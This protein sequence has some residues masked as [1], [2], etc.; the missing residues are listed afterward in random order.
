MTLII[1]TNSFPFG[2]GEE[3]FIEELNFLAKHYD[4]IILI[5]ENSNGKKR[6]IKQQNIKIISLTEDSKWSKLSLILSYTFWLLYIKVLKKSKNLNNDISIKSF[7]KFWNKIYIAKKIKQTLEKNKIN[8]NDTIF[9]SYWFNLVGSA[10]IY[11]K[12]KTKNIKLVVKIHGYDFNQ[13]RY[14][15]FNF[16]HRDFELTQ[17]EHLISISKFG[18]NY[19]AKN[20]ESNINTTVIR[21]GTK[22][23]GLQ[24]KKDKTNTLKIVSC[25]S[26]IPIKR[27]H[28]I[29]EILGKIKDIPIEWTHLGGGILLDEL[30]SRSKMLSK[31][32]KTTFTGHLNQKELIEHYKNNYFD[33]FIHLSETEG[34]PVSMMEAISFGIPI[35]SYNTG[36]VSEIV[37]KK[38]GFLINSVNDAEKHIIEIANKNSVETEKIRN[39]A[40][41]FWEENFHAKNNYKKLVQYINK[42]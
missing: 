1:F 7:R 3:F 35:I 6:N 17:L 42:I 25:S 36:G 5:P 4:K 15:E 12:I 21:L 9:Y 26:L 34:I 11:F 2:I 10:L 14:K 38:S 27:V 37:T 32:I 22:D 40:R 31:N 8:T 41:N 28:L 33:L 19:I 16:H 18:K 13:M 24:K 20:Y 39:S 30:K 29:I 23:Y